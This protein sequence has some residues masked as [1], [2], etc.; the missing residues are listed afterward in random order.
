MTPVGV[1]STP[2]DQQH[3]SVG[4]SQSTSQR[5]QGRKFSTTDNL[6]HLHTNT[7][8]I[9]IAKNAQSLD[10]E[11]RAETIGASEQV[12]VRRTKDVPEVAKQAGIK[13]EADQ[14]FIDFNLWKL[15]DPE[16]GYLFNAT[17]DEVKSR[18]YALGKSTIL[19]EADFKQ[20]WSF[21]ALTEVKGSDP[22]SQIKVQW[23]KN[24]QVQA[25][26]L[27]V[28][29]EPPFYVAKFEDGKIEA[30]AGIDTLMASLFGTKH[31]K[32]DRIE[33][34]LYKY[35]ERESDDAGYDTE[36]Q[37]QY[38]SDKERATKESAPEASSSSDEEEGYRKYIPV[39]LQCALKP[40]ASS[41]SEDEC[42]PVEQS[43]MTLRTGKK[44]YYRPEL[45]SLR[46]YFPPAHKLPLNCR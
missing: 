8:G 14:F 6:G 34:Y 38:I 15:R 44:V 45:V 21:F 16:A 4:T 40:A 29:S 25:C 33:K 26:T 43:F 13:N 18:L 11:V 42:E 7:F 28:W 9:W 39:H 30:F 24:G 17:E 32:L 12:K 36:E 46:R 10:A 22:Q 3:M 41:S 31:V 5:Y 1:H 19:Q 2:L 20:N 35:E 37:E 23:L 27:D